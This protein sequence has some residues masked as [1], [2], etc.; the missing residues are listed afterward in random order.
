MKKMEQIS[1]EEMKSSIVRSGYLMELEINSTLEELGFV[2]HLNDT[3]TDPITQKDRE[4]DINASFAEILNE[5]TLDEL[6]LNL[7]IECENNH[8]PVVFFK[9]SNQQEIIIDRSYDLNII[10]CPKKLSINEKTISMNVFGE[11]YNRHPS[12]FIHPSTQYC[13]FHKPKSSNSNWIASH[14]ESQHKT[15]QNLLNATKYFSKRYLDYY[16]KQI[17]NRDIEPYI[18]LCFLIPLIVVSNELYEATASEK[19]LKL[20]PINHTQFQLN[21]IENNSTKDLKIDI[22]TKKHLS[23]Y[24]EKTVKFYS[25]SFNFIEKEMN[26]IKTNVKTQVDNYRNRPIFL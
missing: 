2:C 9:N 18:S 7:L 1:I 3:Y 17:A 6:Q 16:L 10:G 12:Y 14:Q 21:Y 4:I 15:I 11:F 5:S 26:I 19:G 24:L 20:E 23:N 22:V 25:Q 8:Q 13:S